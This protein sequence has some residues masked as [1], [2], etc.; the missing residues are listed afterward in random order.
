MAD[1]EAQEPG[2]ALQYAWD[3]KM[4]AAF[5]ACNAQRI[6]FTPL[7]VE[8]L[9]GWHPEAEKRIERIGRELTHSTSSSDQ[10]TSTN[11]LFQRHSSEGD[12]RAYSE[13]VF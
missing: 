10:K 5:D 3:R 8:A 1:R 2:C 4:R 6:S 11:H 13:P 12:C 7:P 9:G